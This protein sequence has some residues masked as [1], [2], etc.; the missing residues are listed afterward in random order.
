[1]GRRYSKSAGIEP[2]RSVIPCVG[3]CF[4]DIQALLEHKYLN[5]IMVYTH[6]LNLG[7]AGV[8]SPMDWF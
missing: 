5:M 3:F 1:M 7:A 8:S 2:P 4:F 6:L